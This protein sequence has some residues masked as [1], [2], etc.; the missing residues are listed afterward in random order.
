M[1][2]LLVSVVLAFQ[3]PETGIP[4]SAKTAVVIGDTPEAMCAVIYAAREEAIAA[5]EKQLDALPSRNDWAKLS[6][7]AQEKFKKPLRTYLEKLKSSKTIQIAPQ[8]P[9]EVTPGKL[10]TMPV[11][12]PPQDGWMLAR[13]LDKTTVLAF[14]AIPSAAAPQVWKRKYVVMEGVRGIKKDAKEGTPINTEGLWQ[15][16]EDMKLQDNAYP[17]LLRSPNEAAVKK[18][19]PKYLAEREA[20]KKK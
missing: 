13:Q 5:T 3:N 12:K 19:W 11:I 20:K 6:P 14:W 8:T 16:L 1:I 9:W 2:A 18:M 10:F 7:E 17:H 15:R 4:V